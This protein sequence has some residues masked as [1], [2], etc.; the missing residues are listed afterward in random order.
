[1][2]RPANGRTERSGT[3]L[4]LTADAGRPRHAPDDAAGERR[5]RGGAAGHR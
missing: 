4:S 5:G 1:M 3:S 2:T